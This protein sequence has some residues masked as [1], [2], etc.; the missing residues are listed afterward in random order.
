MKNKMLFIITLLLCTGTA[1]GQSNDQFATT[2][3]KWMET[4]GSMNAFHASIAQTMEMVKNMSPEISETYLEEMKKELSGDFLNEMVEMLVPVY[5][6]Y[7]TIKDLEAAIRF[8]ETPE[9]VKF[10]KSQGAIMSE[11]ML[12]G[13]EW[14]RK[15]GEGIQKKMLEGKD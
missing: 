8:Y 7:L 3:K 6:K 1:F 15:I 2:L 13:Q 4:S 9:G 14:G 11:S 5:E 10:A 12:I